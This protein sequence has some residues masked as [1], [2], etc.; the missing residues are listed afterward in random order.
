MTE[1]QEL[2]AQGIRRAIAFIPGTRLQKSAKLG[3]S[4]YTI[5]KW[6]YAAA[7][8]TDDHMARLARLASEAAPQ[9]GIDQQWIR[10]GGKH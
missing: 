7:K 3:V 8:P 5:Q 9:Y 6:E 10:N 1:E 4:P 2:L